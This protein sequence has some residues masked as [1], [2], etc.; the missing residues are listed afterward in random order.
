MDNLFSEGIID[1]EVLA[2]SF[3]PA[4]SDNDTNGELTFGG[5]TSSK[6]TGSINYVYVLP[7]PINR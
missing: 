2:V 1:T 3:A 7:C 5:T 4:T 6:Y